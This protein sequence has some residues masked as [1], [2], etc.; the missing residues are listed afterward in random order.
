MTLHRHIVLLNEETQNLY[1]E[2]EK[3]GMNKQEIFRSGLREIHRKLISSRR[4]KKVPLDLPTDNG[5]TPEEHCKRILD[6][7]VVGDSCIVKWPSG[8]EHKIGLFRV[9]EFNSREELPI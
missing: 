2:L 3:F 8:L 4:S 6:G 9:K 5:L 7:V 1:E